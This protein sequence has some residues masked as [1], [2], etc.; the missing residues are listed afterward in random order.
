M[1]DANIG[2]KVVAL[3]MGA[4]LMLLIGRGIDDQLSL[5]RKLTEVVADLKVTQ[6]GLVEMLRSIERDGSRRDA[7]IDVLTRQLDGLRYLGPGLGNGNGD[8]DKH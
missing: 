7:R 4:I 2:W 1:K 6:A 8:G 3:G 5:N